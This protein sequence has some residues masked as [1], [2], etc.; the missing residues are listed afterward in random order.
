MVNVKVIYADIYNSV[1]GD[2]WHG[3]SV[4]AILKNVSAENAF[5][6]CIENAHSIAELVLHMWAWTFE[7]A[8]RIKGKDP[9]EP[10]MGDWPKTF[11]NKNEKG[12]AEIKE[13][14]YSST[15]D[16][17]EL[18]KNIDDNNLIKVVGY[19]RISSLGTGKTLL[20]TLNGLAQHN[21]YHAGQISLIKKCFAENV[22]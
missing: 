8:G 12:W 5:T 2:P 6:Y 13:L 17:L 14:F 4:E 10:I 15:R 3:A 19:N 18:L 7:V 20:E 11:I 16:L 9:S 1:F 21:A 22:S